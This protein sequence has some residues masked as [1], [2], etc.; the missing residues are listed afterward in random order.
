MEGSYP[1]IS[2]WPDYRL[3]QIRWE[4]T[5]GSGPR[6]ARR[7][8]T[9]QAYVPG[10]ISR[11]RWAFSGE[12]SQAAADAQAAAERAEAHAHHVGVGALAHRLL[13]SEAL[14]SSQIEGVQ[15]PGHRAIARASIGGA[16]R[17]PARATLAN[18]E[19]IEAAVDWARGS[20]PFS[21]ETFREIHE[22]LATADRWLASHA[23][24]IRTSQNW[25]GRSASTPAGAEFVPPP[26][27]EV[28]RLLHD[29]ADFL[30]RADLP[31]VLQAAIAHAQFETIHPFADGNGRV[32]RTLI[33]A[34]LVRARVSNRVLPPVSL[35]LAG[36]RP[37]YVHALT[38]WRFDG[39]AEL[40]LLVAGA[41]EQSALA[42]IELSD[43]I[44]ALTASWRDRLPKLRAGSGYDLLIDHLP[45]E[46]I[47]DVARAATLIE[48]SP[49]SARR[50]LA[51]LEDAS[52]VRQISAG[53]RNR[54]WEAVGLFALV[55]QMERTLSRGRVGGGDT[56]G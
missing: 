12:V 45:T 13:R 28:P 21:I 18:L 33:G 23:G 15:I 4:P 35:V 16:V 20:D 9:I 52:V 39:P 11:R 42:T 46:P 40:L 2:D 55:D 24:T 54:V 50:A 22:R 19:A 48:R 29:L 32:G 37:A 36:D 1:R 26:H 10:T 30:E 8:V 3:E 43:Q 34:T 17:A 41:V 25:I 49:E 38:S 47:L 56:R 5:A 51:E 27:Q 6:A 53:R 31:P 44:A 7:P 14:A